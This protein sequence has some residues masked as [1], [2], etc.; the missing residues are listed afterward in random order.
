M[1]VWLDEVDST[2]AE[3]RRRAEAGEGGPLWIAAR[4]QTAG[5]GRRG[6]GWSTG[7]GHLAAT[8]L[9]PPEAPASTLSFIAA[10]AVADLA[11]AY[12]PPALVG[13][14]WPNDVLI[15]GHK[16]SGILIEAGAAAGRPWL[17]VGIGV[18]LAAAPLGLERPATAIADHLGPGVSAPPRPEE[19]LERLAGAFA[20][21]TAAWRAG[22]LEAVLGPWRARST[23]LPGPC[24][25]RLPTET[26]HGEA[27][28]IDD[29]GVLRLR[30]ADGSLRRIA[31]G[32]VFFA[33]A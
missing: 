18:N 1:I 9:V 14:K 29:D 19:A 11:D 20:L 27:E 24:E 33:G 2:N 15:A 28:G 16:L 30:L 31:A 17:A 4:R 8:L 22:G 26:L 21:W 5:R 32:D 6:R 10:L 25:V 3:A 12:V 7:A 23:G 13:L